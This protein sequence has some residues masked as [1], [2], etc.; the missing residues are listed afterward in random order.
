ML[1]IRLKL[2]QLEDNRPNLHCLNLVLFPEAV[3]MGKS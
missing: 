2:L 1:T 3:E